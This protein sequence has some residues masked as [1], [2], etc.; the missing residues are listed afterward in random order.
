MIRYTPI[1]YAIRSKILTDLISHKRNAIHTKVEALPKTLKLITLFW[2]VAISTALDRGVFCREI[3]TGISSPKRVVVIA[4]KFERGSI[5]P[6]VE[7]KN[8]YVSPIVFKICSHV[9]KICSPKKARP[10]FAKF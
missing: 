4:V 9:F 3:A 7:F 6:T 10:D 2:I 1:K 8:L 5:F